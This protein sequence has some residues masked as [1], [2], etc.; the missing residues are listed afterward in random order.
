VT[1]DPVKRGAIQGRWQPKSGQA[2]QGYFQRRRG[3]QN[4][5][6]ASLQT[7]SVL[8][9]FHSTMGRHR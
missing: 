9:R 6:G 1:A 4:R 5:H 8:A 7:R 3:Q 2:L